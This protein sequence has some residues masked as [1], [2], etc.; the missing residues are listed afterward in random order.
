MKDAV[1]DLGR[2]FDPCLNEVEHIELKEELLANILVTRTSQILAQRS[3]FD[4][5]RLTELEK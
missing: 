3:L 5:R 4:L 1:Y 2:G